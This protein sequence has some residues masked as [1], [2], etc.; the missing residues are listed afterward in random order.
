MI[1]TPEMD[2]DEE[3]DFLAWLNSEQRK[4]DAEEDQAAREMLYKIM[5][6]QQG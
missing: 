1:R 6:E 2:A 3:Q 5:L 4:M